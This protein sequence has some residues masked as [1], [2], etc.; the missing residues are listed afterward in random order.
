MSSQTYLEAK[1]VFA[2]LREPFEMQLCDDC[3]E[4]KNSDNNA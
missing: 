1:L 2:L 3:N 4:N